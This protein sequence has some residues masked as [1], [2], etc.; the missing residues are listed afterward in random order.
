MC[1]KSITGRTQ[2]TARGDLE[3]VVD[4]AELADAAHHLDAERDGA[5]LRLEPLA[6]RRRA[7]RRRRRASARASRPSQKPGW[8]TTDLGAAGGR[9]PGR[10]VERAER[11]LRLLLV[12]VARER[13]ER[14]VHRER[15]LRARARARRAAPPTGSRARSRSRSRARRPSS[16]ARASSSTAGR[17][18]PARGS[19]PGRR[20]SLPRRDATGQPLTRSVRADD[21]VRRGSYPFPHGEGTD[22]HRPARARHRPPARRP[23]AR[24]G[25]VAEWNLEVD[26]RVHA[27]RVRQG[28]LRRADRGRRPARSATTTATGFPARRE[29]APRTV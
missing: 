13:E 11:H 15:D 17:A 7:T 9:D 19:A 5:A 6:Q 1:A 29:T 22:P 12:R 25:E 14:R 24:G 23:L 10:A 18:T 21:V 16:R 3:H 20:G 8:M 28:L 26:G 2:A 4:R 27:R